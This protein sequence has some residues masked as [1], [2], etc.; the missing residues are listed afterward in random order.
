MPGNRSHFKTLPEQGDLPLLRGM[1]PTKLAMQ[2]KDQNM[3]QL[4]HS[5]QEVP[6]TLQNR[7]SSAQLTMPTNTI[8]LRTPQ[9]RKNTQEL[10]RHTQPGQHSP[11]PTTE[12]GTLTDTTET[13]VPILPITPTSVPAQNT[14]TTKPLTERL[15]PLTTGNQN[16]AILR[17]QINIKV[18]Q[19][20]LQK[21]RAAD[22]NLINT[23]NQNQADIILVQEPYTVR[24]VIH[25]TQRL[26]T[27]YDKSAE[28]PRAA[29][30][31][32]NPNWHPTLIHSSKD[33][34]AVS[35]NFI[36][37]TLIFISVYSDG[38]EYIEDTI[39]TLDTIIDNYR[40]KSII[41]G[42]DFNSWNKRWGYPEHNT[43]GHKLLEFIEMKGLILQN[44][45]EDPPTFEAATGKGWPDLTFTTTNIAQHIANWHVSDTTSCSDHHNIIFEINTETEQITNTRYNTNSRGNKFKQNIKKQLQGIEQTIN[46]CD[47]KHDLEALTEYIIDQIQEVSENTF[48]I[49][50]AKKQKQANWWT[51]ELK[52]QKSKTRALK[53]R[54]KKETDQTIKDKIKIDY[55][56]ELATYKKQILQ[57]K[58]QKWNEFCTKNKSQ[59]G[60]LHKI[61][62]KKTFKPTNFQSL[63][64]DPNHSQNA[65]TILNKIADALFLKDSPTNDTQDQKYIRDNY[66]D[67]D[68]PDDLPFTKR[69]I[70]HIIKN[71]P[72]HKAPGPDSIDNQIIKYINQACPLLFHSLFNKCLDLHCFPKTF[73]IG[74]LTLFHKSNKDPKLP[75]SYRPINLLPGIGKAL[76]KLLIQR[77]RHS[78]VKNKIYH[79]NQYG[80]MPGVS[81]EHAINDVI[82][83]IKNQKNKKHAL[84]ITLDLKGAFDSLWWPQVLKSLHEA[85]TPANIF[86]T[87]KHYLSDRQILILHDGGVITRDIDRGCPQGSCGGPELWNLSFNDILSEDWPPH[88]T[89][90]AFADDVSMIV[91]GDTREKLES[92][93]KESLELFDRCCNNHKLTIADNKSNALFFHKDKP[94]VRKPKIHFNGK[95]IKIVDEI[96]YLGVYIDTKLSWLPHI[97]YLKVKTSV[98]F[99]ILRTTFGTRWGLSSK[100]LKVLYLTV[101]EPTVCH[102]AAVWGNKVTGRKLKQVT[103]LQR[104]FVLA[105][106]RG[107]RTTA[108]IDATLLS[109][110]LPLHIK[111]EEEAMRARVGR[112]GKTEQYEGITFHHNQYEK[113]C[114][115]LT[116]HPA[117][118]GKGINIV[119][120]KV[121][122]TNADTVIYTDGSKMDEGVGSAYVQYTNNTETKTWQITL[123]DTNSVFQAEL[124]AIKHAIEHTTHQ[125]YQHIAILS[126]SN[127]SLQA[128]NDPSNT[129]PIVKTIQNSLH[130][131]QKHYSLQWIKA[132][133][134]NTGNDR[135][136]ELAKQAVL[137]KNTIPHQIPLP[138]SHLKKTLRDLSIS[139]WQEQWTQEGGGRRLYSFLHKVDI[140]RNIGDTT[141]TQFYTGHAPTPS[142]FH[143]IGRVN[144]PNCACGEVGDLDHYAYTCQLTTGL[145]FRHPGHDDSAQKRLIPNE[146]SLTKTCRAIINFLQ[147]RNRDLCETAP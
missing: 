16:H 131:T 82:E 55:K 140:H 79:P 72:R 49:K 69:E 128:I 90:R 64:T 17:S 1:P 23:I 40:G 89:I 6:D 60:V 119:P 92:N 122:L 22:K 80:F 41:I 121:S 59:Y 57:T 113:K 127:S 29:I 11:S 20:N 136:D 61:I 24:N 134:N 78:N 118:T 126:D 46:N 43:R 137:Q 102:A 73:K 35:L 123:R 15:R 25:S 48:K 39:H 50:S 45:N 75:D 9:T 33:I 26:N 103:S 144:S 67:I 7:S 145:H 111:I 120:S 130:K 138:L 112:M 117:Q 47:N 19:I 4:P 100:F 96:K 142:Y 81:T 36:N 105:I 77:L 74:Q 10:G 65:V 114:H 3:P 62:T 95:K 109:G 104:N 132:H 98:M 18:I 54:L 99:N 14:E 27:F 70:D 124:T 125:K 106:S 88:T 139:R 116:K 34:I 76:E 53:R 42:G 84:L 71:L 2:N 108:T 38:K 97:Q 37:K 135:A 86:Y 133:N 110:V 58:Y 85:K 107:Y 28:P 21:A 93:A 56:R 32:N 143:K 63:S 91:T 51:P 66:R 141:L 147:S 52:T 44:T 30:L 83:E 68:T 115:F 12:E 146:K 129:S 5:Q 8:S 87:L 13:N 31:I 94:L 101:I